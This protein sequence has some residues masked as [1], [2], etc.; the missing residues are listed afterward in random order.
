MKEFR[1]RDEAG[2]GIA[3]EELPSGGVHIIAFHESEDPNE[4]GAGTAVELTREQAKQLM[5]WLQ[6]ATS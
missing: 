1:V 2:F 3:A 4:A 6:G 5:E